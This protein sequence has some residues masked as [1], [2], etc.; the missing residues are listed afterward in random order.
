VLAIVSAIAVT[1][2]ASAT[3][4]A[5]PGAVPAQHGVT[6][7]G[8]SEVDGHQVP[9]LKD[10]ALAPL[11][12]NAAGSTHI[13]PAVSSGSVNLVVDIS[14]RCADVA[15]YG[16]GN[17]D[18]VQQ[19]AC[20]VPRTQNQSWN[21]VVVANYIDAAGNEYNVDQIIE[22]GTNECM[23]AYN[24]G[25]NNGTN[26]DIYN[27][28]PAEQMHG[29]QLWIVDPDH[30]G[31]W[32]YGATVDRSSWISLDVVCTAAT[33]DAHNNGA[34]VQLWQSNTQSPCYGENEL[35]NW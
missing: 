9:T 1:Q 35:W 21:F 31:I 5:A 33:G 27:C 12:T 25:V 13:K 30:G 22:D 32:N 17:L 20:H 4:G 11:P 2:P 34:N 18:N 7:V 10:S 28:A 19:W 26:V 15:N 23:E 16:T 3:A 6:V 14:D 24:W 29:N 8:T